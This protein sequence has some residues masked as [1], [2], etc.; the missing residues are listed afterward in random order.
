M[1][2]TVE[3]G[4]IL[5]VAE[6]TLYRVFLVPLAHTHGPGSKEARQPT[7]WLP[8]GI[9]ADDQRRDPR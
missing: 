4:W 1:P 7:K 8:M 2:F 9:E 6:G 5:T 3:S